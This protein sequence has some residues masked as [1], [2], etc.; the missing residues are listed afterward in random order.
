M[1]DVAHAALHDRADL[2]LPF[3]GLGGDAAH[4]GHVGHALDH[5]HVAGLREV[6]RFEFRH[7]VDL[8]ARTLE[9]VDALEDVA[10][11]QR[12][13]GDGPAGDGRPQHRRADDARRDAELIHG[14]RDDAGRIA[15]RDEPLDHALRR[16]RYRHQLDVLGRDAAGQSFRLCNRH[17]S[18]SRSSGFAVSRHFN[19]LPRGAQSARTAD[20]ALDRGET[21][22]REGSHCGRTACPRRAPLAT[23]AAFPAQR[24]AFPRNSDRAH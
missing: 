3:P 16:A 2:A 6:V 15:Q 12:R 19:L 24:F 14:V 4:V 10:H 1:G 11:G 5:Q 7:P 17:W 18:A 22:L 8:P 23:V 20:G 9:R 21:A 13:S